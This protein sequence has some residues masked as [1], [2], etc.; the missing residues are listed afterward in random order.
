MRCRAGIFVQ[1]F[2][3]KVANGYKPEFKGAVEERCFRYKRSDPPSTRRAF[4]RQERSVGWRKRL[5]ASLRAGFVWA[6]FLGSG[7]ML[8]RRLNPMLNVSNIRE[9]F[10]W[11]EKL[12]W[13]KGWDWGDTASFGSGECEIFLCENGQRGTW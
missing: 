10:A 11:F 12:A 2:Y 4:S 3:M 13:K 9:S 8:A 6:F 5:I 7:A 1:T